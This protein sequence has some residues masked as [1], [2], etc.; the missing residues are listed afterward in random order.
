MLYGEERKKLIVEH[1]NQNGRASVQ[2]LC[3]EFQVSESTVRRDLK[4]LEE[5]KLIKRAHGGA[6]SLQSVNFEP[7]FSEK[8]DKFQ[9]EKKAIAEVAVSLIEE[10][11]T[12]LLDSGTTTFYMLEGLK[13]FSRLTVVTNSLVIA[14]ELQFHTKIDV[15]V[16]GG[17]LRSD[18]ISLV[19][20]V[21][22]QSLNMIRVDKVF[23]GTN[24]I[25]LQEGLTTPNILEAETKKRMIHAAKQVIVL[26]DHSKVGKVSFAKI[27]E[28]TNI[29]KCIT[30]S[31]A[32]Q[33]FINGLEEKGVDVYVAE[34]AEARG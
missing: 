19:G 20:P 4:E 21:T 13:Q 32:P 27:E 12:I 5:E 11:D 25:D 2:E 15:L 28:L 34:I 22:N 14:L 17:S 33:I 29:D 31:K 23:I 6:V 3:A 7:S 10:G 16:L 30:D 8:E 26:T 24:G 1:V 18:T 9:S